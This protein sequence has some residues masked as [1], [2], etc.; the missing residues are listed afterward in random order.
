MSTKTNASLSILGII[1]E[2]EIT[3]LYQPIISLINGE[4][5]GYEALSR[6]PK[7]TDF[8]SP[9]ALI[10]AAEDEGC[11]WQLEM[12]FRRKAIE[13]AVAIPSNRYLFLNVDPNV[14]LDTNYKKGITKSYLNLYNIDKKDIVFEITERTAIEDY[15]RFKAI[16]DHY[17][18]QEYNIAIDDVGSGYSGLRSIT[19]LKPDFV[20]IDMDLIRDIDTDVFKKSIVKGLVSV[21]KDTGLQLIAEG[22]ETLAELRTIIE[23][24]VHNAQGFLLHRPSAQVITQSP[25][26]RNLI[27]QTKRES[28]SAFSYDTAYFIIGK[29][30]SNRKCVS[31]KATCGEL[32]ERFDHSDFDSVTICDDHCYPEGLIMRTKFN[33]KLADRYGYDLYSQRPVRLLMDIRPLIIDYYTPVNQVLSLA[34][35]RDKQY[36]YDDIVVTK[37]SDYFGNVSLY[38]IIRYT[39][40]YEK[41]YA[42]QLNPLTSLPGNMIIRQVLEQYINSNQLIGLLYIDLDH[43][44]SYNDV[45]GFEQGDLILKRTAQIIEQWVSKSSETNFV[46]HIGGDD[47]VAVLNES[48]DNLVSVCQD[49]C[50]EFQAMI[51]SFFSK[52]DQEQGYYVAKDRYDTIKKYPLT[53]IT[54][55]GY[56]GSLTDL[57]TPENTGQVMGTIKREAKATSGNSY[58]LVTSVL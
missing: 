26:I 12:L 36:L 2:E 6:G 47:Y 16:T 33:S 52:E 34:M 25:D 4:I 28:I 15:E 45:Y 1:Q 35:Q 41:M 44:K 21:A 9:V 58:K 55:A 53:S 57:K 5:I 19:E 29:I 56:F 37:T 30:T 10:H 31:S 20:K 22:V 38:D 7:D 43:F 51:P 18:L 48:Y 50:H 42:K 17:R 40:E 3:T 11:L 39:T 49:I 13:K 32:K 27:L 14:M 54:I 24:G 46:G 8:F 23:L